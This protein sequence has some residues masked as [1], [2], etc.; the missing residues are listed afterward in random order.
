MANSSCRGCLIV[1][2]TR[3]A[4]QVNLLKRMFKN[5]MGDLAKKLDINTI[6]GF[7]V[8]SKHHAFP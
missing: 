2:L 1:L 8:G 5:A 6:D 4:V 3:D 7:Q